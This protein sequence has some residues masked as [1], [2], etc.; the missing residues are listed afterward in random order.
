MLV[1]RAVKEV[2]YENKGKINRCTYIKFVALTL[3]IAF[4]IFFNVEESRP[5]ISWVAVADN[6]R[7]SKDAVP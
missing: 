1:L 7:S 5:E 3:L 4:T 2:F 6:L